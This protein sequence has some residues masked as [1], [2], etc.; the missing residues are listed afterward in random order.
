MKKLKY[1]S[2]SREPQEE[3]PR[4][5]LRMFRLGEGL[6]NITV[7]Q[8]ELQDMWDTLLGRTPPPVKLRDRTL[9]LMEVAD[10][11]HARA[12]EIK[13]HIQTLEAEGRI[14]KGTA[15][16]AFRTGPLQN[17]IDMSRKASDLGSRRLT[18]ESLR[19]EAEQRG[20]DY[21]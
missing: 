12:L 2:R 1:T 4:G 3:M 9:A 7:L 16:Y 10:A 17:F 21:D 11:Y 15:L 8:E 5:S 14:L 20:R 18:E 19:T 13:S 6:P